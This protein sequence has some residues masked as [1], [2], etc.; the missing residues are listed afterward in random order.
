MAEWETRVFVVHIRELGG[1]LSNVATWAV[2]KVK[3]GAGIGRMGMVMYQKIF[4]CA[5]WLCVGSGLMAELRMP[6]VFSDHMVL[7]Q[8]QADPIWGWDDPGTTV[9]VTFAGQKKTALAGEDGKWS[10]TLDAMPANGQPQVMT[11]EGSKRVE[12]KDVLIGEV[13]LCSG[14]SN[15]EWPLSVDWNGDLEELAAGDS[16]FRMLSIPKFGT[17]DAQ[18]FFHGQWQVNHAKVVKDFSAVGYYYGQY[19]SRVLKV[20]VGMIDNAWGGSAAEAWVPRESLKTSPILQK[21]LDRA[22]DMET[23]IAATPTDKPNPWLSGNAR[24]GNLY[25]GVLHPVIGYGIKGVI[26]YQ[27]ETNASRAWEYRTLFP[28]LIQ[29]WRKAWKQGDFPFYWVQLADFKD[30]VATPGESDWAELREAQTLAMKLPKTGQA[31][32]IDLGEARDIHPKS[33]QF[34]AAR[35]ARWA[36]ANDYGKSL[37]HRSP[38]M[39]EITIEG[40]KARVKLNLYGGK[41]RPFDTNAI[42]G[43]A[44]CGEDHVWVAANAKI[45]QPDQI[46][47]SSANVPNPIAVRYAWANNPVVNLTNEQGLPLTPFRSDDFRLLTQ[48]KENADESNESKD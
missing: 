33:K 34:V 4:V 40:G 14:Q 43:F 8:Q 32:I 41:L 9:T 17:Q 36:L 47:V 46:E 37:V 28:H 18:T 30:E 22:E 1:N 31:V 15:M 38:E 5:L 16:T 39:K 7:Q 21:I 42:Q 25:Q 19:L 13:W 44:I 24:P 35:L 48:P 6:G 11:V 27:G 45:H 10:V 20:P 3:V 12:L 23:K 26:W 2:A 29:E